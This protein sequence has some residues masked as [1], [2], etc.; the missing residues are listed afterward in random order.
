M[1]KVDF[2]VFLGPEET[3]YAT[4]RR[5][6]LL[7]EDL[8]YHSLWISDHLLGVYQSPASKRLECWTTVSALAAITRRIRL[9]QI[10]LAAPFRPPSLLAKMAATLDVISDG[11]VES[12][13]RLV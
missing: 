1:D 2:G 12:R 10:T 5:R 4:L 3:S 8:D 9:G 6:A 13:C 7:C 11:R